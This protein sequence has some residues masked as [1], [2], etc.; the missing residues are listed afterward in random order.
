MNFIKDLFGNHILISAVLGW[1]FA[2][3]IKI[4]FNCIQ[5]K[6]L[7]NFRLKDLFASGGMPSSHS[8]AVCALSAAIACTFG[9]G[10]VYFA[11]ASTFSGIIMYD[12]GGVRKEAGEQA[13]ALN[14]IMH[15]MFSGNPEYTHKAF[16]ELIGHTK[17]QVFVGAVLGITIGI[18]YTYFMGA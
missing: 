3:L 7:R 18:L 2:E 9:V 10:S 17:S 12:A 13:K 14:I 5:A 16:K 8:A 15:D 1:F 6:S 4:I 11:I